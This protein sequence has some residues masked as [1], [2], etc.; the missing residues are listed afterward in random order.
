M[1]YFGDIVKRVLEALTGNME[2]KAESPKKSDPGYPMVVPL[3]LPPPIPRFHDQRRSNY[4][5]NKD[6][7]SDTRGRTTT[8]SKRTELFLKLNMSAA[9]AACVLYI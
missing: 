7:N 4:N 3:P 2:K 1:K 5:Q 6:Q 8:D 9:K